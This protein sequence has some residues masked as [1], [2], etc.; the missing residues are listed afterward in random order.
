MMI[1]AALQWPDQSEKALWPLA[2]EDAVHLHNNLPSQDTDLSPEELWMGLQSSHAALTHARVWGCPAYM[3]EPRLQDGK[4]I[5]KWEPRSRHGQ[6]V[7]VSAQH[8][9]SVGVIRNLRTGNLS[10]QFHVVYDNFFETVHSGDDQVPTGWEDLV[11]YS[12]DRV[13]IDEDDPASIPELADEWVD[14]ATL[15]TPRRRRMER[16]DTTPK[17]ADSRSDKPQLRDGVQ[18]PAATVTDPSDPDPP[19]ATVNPPTPARP[20]PVDEAPTSAGTCRSTQTRYQMEIY[21]PGTGGLEC[22]RALCMS[23]AKKVAWSTLGKR[24]YSLVYALL[25]DP[26]FGVVEAMLPHV[27]TQCAHMLKASS[28]NL[29]PDLPNLSEAMRG[30]HRDEFLEAM[31]AEI[32]AL[33]KHSTWTLVK[34]T[35]V[36]EGANVLPSTWVFRIKRFPDGRYRKTKARFCMRGDKQQEGVD[37]FDKYA[38]VVSWST[39]RLLLCLSIS[40]GWKTRQVDFSNAF[41]Q[42]ELNEDVYVQLPAMF[43]GPNGETGREVVMKLNRSL[44]G[45]VQAPLYWY[46]HLKA[47]LE[48]PSIGFKASPL[49]P[50]LFYGN[51]MIVLVYVDDCLFFGPDQ[52]KID[53][54]I[55]KLQEVKKLTL[56]VE[57]EDA[58]AFLGVDVKPNGKGGYLM[59]QAG[60]IKKVLKTT[61]LEGCN[62]KATP[63]NVAPLG[64][65]E[66]GKPYQEEWNYAS[67]VGM[68]LYLSSNSRPDIQFA[69]HQCARFT[70]NPKQSHADAIK[71][72]CRYLQATQDKGLEFTPTSDMALDLY[73]DADFAGLWNY[74]DDQD[75]VCVK[76]RTGYVITLGSCPM[77]WVSKLQ[78]EIA[79][80]ALEVEYIALST[81]MRDLVPLRRLMKEIGERCELDFVKPAMVHSTIFEDNNG[82]LGLATAPKLTPRTKHI[83]VKYHWFKSLIGKEHGFEIVKVESRDQKA[84]IFTKGLPAE[85]FEHVRKILMGW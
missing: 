54:V 85:T 71:W 40:N 76:S 16:R 82:A 12:S 21:S 58:Y 52:D 83:G 53:E 44:Y 42:A 60:L 72:I 11:T 55:R 50:C 1:H 81:A 27:G 35:S 39:V 70:H 75:P 41:V 2:L 23:L 78:T 57:K 37:Y 22:G 84:D 20:V 69:V 36:P 3:L 48:D 28:S 32:A 26:E 80:S 38:P 47:S 18:P 49:D 13:L 25:M 59:T 63:A 34:R 19:A 77:I 9:S 66:D 10:P 56:T 29:D 68:L 73:V 8:A 6:F 43:Q 61:K 31:G 74:E 15:E 45:L 46:N 67:V 79:L 33:E 30:P 5:P 65:N 17:P 7:G 24:D 64:T 51:G 14:D 4:K 62:R